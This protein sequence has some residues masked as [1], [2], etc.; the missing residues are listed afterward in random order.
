MPPIDPRTDFQDDGGT[1]A[2]R[3]NAATF[4]TIDA[5]TTN[6]WRLFVWGFRRVPLWRTMLFLLVWG[7]FG[8]VFYFISAIAL[9]M[10]SGIPKDKAPFIMVF[11]GF[12]FVVVFGCSL[13]RF[14]KR[15]SRM[16]K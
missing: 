14:V 15:Y 10:G 9:A 2:W 12:L 6:E 7:F 16:G 1:P 5:P 3:A 11:W 8:P 4:R 13:N